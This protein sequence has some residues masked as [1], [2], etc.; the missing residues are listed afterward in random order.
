[1]F[2]IHPIGVA[3]QGLRKVSKTSSKCVNKVQP[4]SAKC[5]SISETTADGDMGTIDSL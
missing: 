1:M 5:K 4:A 2:A 3:F